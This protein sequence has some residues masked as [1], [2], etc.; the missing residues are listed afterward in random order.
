MRKIS[1]SILL[2]QNISRDKSRNVLIEV[3]DTSLADAPSTVVAEQQLKNVPLAPSGAIP[4]S[5]EVPD[6]Q[7]QRQLSLRVHL[8]LDGTGTVTAGDLMNVQAY[9]VTQGGGPLNVKVV[10]V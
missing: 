5:L 10:A 4:F 8:D 9:P 1:G 7:S 3:R 6:V 2:P